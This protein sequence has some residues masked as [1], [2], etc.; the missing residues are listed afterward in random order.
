MVISGR[1]V[2]SSGAISFPTAPA[3]LMISPMDGAILSPELDQ[4]A[5]EAV[6]SGR[7]GSRDEVIAAGL[8]MLRDADIA[9]TSFFGSLDDTQMSAFVRSLDAAEA[10]GE[11]LGFATIDEVV[12]ETDVLLEDMARQSR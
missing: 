2:G 6:A 10:A 4:F 9:V 12:R 11:E 7:Y 8:S 3:P 5:T 1:D